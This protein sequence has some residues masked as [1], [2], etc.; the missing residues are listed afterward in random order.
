MAAV[1]IAEIILIAIN[2]AMAKYHA[3]IFLSGRSV[4]HGWW[5]LAYI[6]ATVVLCAVVKSWQLFVMALIIR[7]VFFDTSLNYFLHRSIYYVSTETTS[8][9]LPVASVAALTCRHDNNASTLRAAS[10]Y[11]HQ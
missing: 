5:G 11:L 6:A 4:K 2:I 7:K 10:F 8:L 9:M 3:K 1:A